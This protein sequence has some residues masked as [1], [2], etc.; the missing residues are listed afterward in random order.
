MA[1]KMIKLSLFCFL[2]LLSYK[3]I[4]KVGLKKSVVTVKEAVKIVQP[5]KESLLTLEKR[6]IVYYDKLQDE[7]LREVLFLLDKE[8]NDTSIANRLLVEA[9]KYFEHSEHFGK[10]PSSDF[11]I[12]AAVLESFAKPLAIK[13][14]L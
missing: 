4:F 14:K 12:V 11:L 10:E 2:I 1:S 3:I 8:H 5:E 13:S 6:A 7:G 9:K